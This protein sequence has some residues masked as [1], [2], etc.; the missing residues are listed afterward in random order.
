[1]PY[2]TRLLMYADI[3]G[4]EAELVSGGDSARLI[5]AM[6]CIHHPGKNLN[7]EYRRVTRR[8]NSEKGGL[9]NLMWLEGQFAAFSDNYVF[10]T[11]E[12]HGSRILNYPRH[13][14]LCLMHM[15][16]LT[17]GAIVIG[18]LVHR[19]NVI[20]GPAL[21]EAVR[22]EQRVADYPRILVTDDVL[23]FLVGKEYE[24]KQVI[25]DQFGKMVINPFS[26]SYADCVDVDLLQSFF[27][28]NRWFPT[29][30][31]LDEQISTLRQKG[32]GR[33]AD[34]WVYMRDF[35]DGPVLD[36]DPAIRRYWL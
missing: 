31:A 19:D 10:S 9:A 16:F 28:S 20:Y 29:R 30:A 15:G 18:D 36:A 32:N 35:I 34:K 21:V 27:T 5:E 1:M 11:P 22:L 26:L 6:E 4:W 12:N 23:K 13:A 17:R 25:K 7:E 2:E 8:D 33:A 3:L 24:P 14:T